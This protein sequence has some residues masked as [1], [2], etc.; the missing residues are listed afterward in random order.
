MSCREP[1]TVATDTQFS[2]L[3]VHAKATRE[4]APCRRFDLEQRHFIHDDSPFRSAATTVYCS[5]NARGETSPG[6][7]S[8]DIRRTFD[9]RC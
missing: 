6:W 4:I 9:R 2:T 8:P 1:F 3:S 7:A 5:T